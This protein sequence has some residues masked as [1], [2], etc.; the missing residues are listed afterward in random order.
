MKVSVL[1]VF[2]PRFSYLY[3]YKKLYY[4]RPIQEVIGK[5]AFKNTQ[6]THPWRLPALVAG[7]SDLSVRTCSA[8]SEDICR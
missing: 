2:Q 5:W 8:S 6:N 3:V 4:R 7:V 1:S